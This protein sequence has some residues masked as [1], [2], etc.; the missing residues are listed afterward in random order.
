VTHN[1]EGLA[2][3][4]E[5]AILS[6]IINL[7]LNNCPTASLLFLSRYFGKHLLGVVSSHQHSLPH[8]VVSEFRLMYKSC[9]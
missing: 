2:E 3:V 1:V 9:T 5:L 7:K 4:A 6:L 8:C